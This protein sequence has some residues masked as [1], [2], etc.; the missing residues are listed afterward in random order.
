MA[1]T[2]D[3]VRKYEKGEINEFPV[4]AATKIYEGA[5]VGDDA[6]GYARGLVAGDPFR[7][8]CLAQ[9]DNSSGAAGAINVKVQ[10]EGMVELTIT[11]VALTDVDADVYASADG[12]FTLTPGSNTRIGTVARF[13]SANTAM[14]SFAASGS[15]GGG[16]GDLIDTAQIR[17]EAVTVGKMADLT[18]GSIIS[19]QTAN[20]R[21]TALDAKTS[22]QIL[23]GDGT[24][25]ASVAVSGDITLAANGAVAIA[26]GVIVNADVN[27]SAAIAGSKISPTFAGPVYP[28]YTVTTDATADNLTHTAAMM[29][30]GLM[31]RD[32]AG[33][34]RSDVTDTAA[35]LVAAISGCAVGS[36]F[37]YVVRNTAD[38]AE[39]ITMT[40][41]AGVTLS[42]TMT[43]AQNNTK[44]FLGVVT[45][46]TAS[47]EAV[48]FYSIGTM[49]H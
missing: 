27:A 10:K 6:S 22:G 46:A 32:P 2:D 37:W 8:F 49:V 15:S 25:L 44:I 38:A 31:L 42:G 45:N 26:S 14:V 12:T 7:G 5:A 3:V 43:I 39:T 13:V 4:K 47:S 20:N 35:N 36:S 17:D 19:G 23:V 30:G 29:V 33:G 28:L 21:P 40:A 1:L 9:A 34:A 11:S 48:T 41:G 18:R 16:T 24:D